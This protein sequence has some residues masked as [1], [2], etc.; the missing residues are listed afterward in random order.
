VN[1]AAEDERR[2]RFLHPRHALAEY[3][4]MTWQT[5]GAAD[6]PGADARCQIYLTAGGTDPR[7][8]AAGFAAFGPPVVVACADWVCEHIGGRTIARARSLSARE[9]ERALALVPAERYAALLVIDALAG[10]LAN[11]PG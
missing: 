6:T 4:N 5:T 8:T 9:V 2:Q 11:L 3:V 1:D 7:L 10:A